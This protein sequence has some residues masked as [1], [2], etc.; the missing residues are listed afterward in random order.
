MTAAFKLTR[1]NRGIRVLEAATTGPVPHADLVRAAVAKLPDCKRVDVYQGDQLVRT[2]WRSWP[3]TI[4]RTAPEQSALPCAPEVAEAEA[5][6]LQCRQGAPVLRSALRARF[7]DATLQ[8]AAARCV[9]RVS[10]TT[11]AGGDVEY[12]APTGGMIIVAASLLQ[13]VVPDAV[14]DLRARA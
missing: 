7:D 12:S 1:P 11:T 3:N 6:I 5:A 10:Q 9:R 14:V 13:H 4:W 8:A 2:Y